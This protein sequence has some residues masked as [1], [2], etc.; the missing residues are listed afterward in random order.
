MLAAILQELGSDFPPEWAAGYRELENLRINVSVGTG[1]HGSTRVF[2]P[3]TMTL[4]TIKKSGLS[5][6]FVEHPLTPLKGGIDV[7]AT[8]H[9]PLEG[10][11]G[12]V[13][14][15]FT[16]NQKSKEVKVMLRLSNLHKHYYSGRKPLHVLKGLI[17]R[18][19]P[20]NLSPSWTLRFREIDA[21]QYPGSVR[22][23]R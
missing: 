4:F 12:G 18:F 20:E 19:N 5:V 8:S 15:N 14:T 22:S 11:K 16:K 23:L 9:S 2:C 7:E 3:P 21:A 1:S 17:Y 6:K 13:S 10:G